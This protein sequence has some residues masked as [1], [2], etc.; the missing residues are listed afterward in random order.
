MASLG[1]T[2]LVNLELGLK[3]LV[4]WDLLMDPP[5]RTD[6]LSLGVVFYPIPTFR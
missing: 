2:T 5:M 4:N 1:L 6:V 3:T